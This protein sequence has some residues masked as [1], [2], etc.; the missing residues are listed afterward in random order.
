M[1]NFEDIKNKFVLVD[2]NFGLVIV[3]ARCVFHKEL[4]SE[5]TIKEGRVLGGGEWEL[6]R[7]TGKLKLFGESYDFGYCQIKDIQSVL[8]KGDLWARPGRE[9]QLKD[10][11]RDIEFEE[12]YPF[13]YLY[14]KFENGKGTVYEKK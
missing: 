13:K 12:V 7:E 6:D 5:K 2:T 4:V 10:N 3:I 11:I 1:V 14:L 9:F 8:E